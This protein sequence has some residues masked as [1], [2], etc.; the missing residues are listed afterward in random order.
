MIFQVTGNE[1]GS[2]AWFASGQH[3]RNTTEQKLLRYKNKNVSNCLKNMEKSISNNFC[4]NH[5]TIQFVEQK[6]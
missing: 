3:E 2:E 6:S 1:F 5:R 4:V